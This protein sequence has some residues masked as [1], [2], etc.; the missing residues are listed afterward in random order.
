MIIYDGYI[1]KK[2]F[3]ND[4]FL[5]NI[6]SISFLWNTDGVPLLKSSKISIWP[7]FLVINELEPKYRCKSENML[8]A[9]IWYS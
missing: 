4:D 6:D 5:S 1:Y 9:G 2:H 7:I 3:E 8:F